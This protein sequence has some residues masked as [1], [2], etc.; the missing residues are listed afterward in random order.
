MADMARQIKAIRT[1]LNYRKIGD[2]TDAHTVT[3][4]QFVR[5][6]ARHWPRMTEAEIVEL[7][8]AVTADHET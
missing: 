1:W 3:H 4:E 7:Y 2:V 5:Y 8:R 6:V